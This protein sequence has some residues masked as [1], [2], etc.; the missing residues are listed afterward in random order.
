MDETTF[1]IFKVQ[2]YF[3][4]EVWFSIYIYI[5]ILLIY[6]SIFSALKR[7]LMMRRSLHELVDQ[8]IYPRK[9]FSERNKTHFLGP[10]Q[11]QLFTPEIHKP[12]RHLF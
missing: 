6:Y 3:A 2:F 4:L 12:T 8:G 5:Y 7:K 1:V 11:P 9:Y 10:T